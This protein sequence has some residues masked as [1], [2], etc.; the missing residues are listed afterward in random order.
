M[1]FA[2]DI[3]NTNIHVGFFRGYEPVHTFTLSTDSRR[4]SDEYAL[5]LRNLTEF[6]G[7]EAEDFR[8]AILGS[9][10]PSATEVI[11]SAI[12]KLLNF[13]PMTVGPGIKTGFSI[14]VDNPSELGAD[15][16]A[17]TAAAIHM[18]GA[19]AFVVDF[20][21][22]TTVSVVSEDRAYLGCCILPGVGM[23]LK[24]LA[25]TELLPGVQTAERVPLLGTNSADSMNAGVIHG[26]CM[27]VTGLI[28]EL[29]R[30]K[31]FPSDTPVLLTG[32]FGERLV[33]YLPEKTRYIPNLTLRGLAVIYQANQKNKR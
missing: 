3:G 1:L 17:N 25:S 4:T 10:V 2:V 24:A 20:G 12:K 22:A 18:V 6:A 8:G 11:A 27:A 31:N 13:P 32:G 5:L 19:P 21:T 16:A 28:R 14:R 26:Q 15:L 29:I 9:V 30:A 23:S 7:Y 33:P